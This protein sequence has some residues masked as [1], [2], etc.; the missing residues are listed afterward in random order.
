MK[1]INL[2]TTHALSNEARISSR[3]R[4]NYNYHT[5]FED[6]INRML[7]AIE[8][9]SYVQPHKHESPDKREIFL[10]LKG[11]LAVVEFND[12]GDIR[13]H[14]V[15]DRVNNFGVEIPPGVWHT[16][17]AL[18]GGTIVYEV[19]DGPYSSLNDKK[20]APWAPREEEETYR[21]YF[22]SLLQKLNLQI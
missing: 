10:L 9:E 7:N 6:P 15:L 13:Q 3:K 5:N 17:I 11:K 12:S 1:M 8:P 19:K 22:E 14:V 16:I 2:K 18:E 4:K 20:F 21:K